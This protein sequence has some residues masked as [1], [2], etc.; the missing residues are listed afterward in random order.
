MPGR[1]CSPGA[2][3]LSARP[4]STRPGSAGQTQ[5]AGAEPSL[6]GPFS[7][8]SRPGHMV[9]GGREG[10]TSASVQR[11]FP[12]AH[13]GLCSRANAA[14]RQLLTKV[15][16]SLHK[17]TRSSLGQSVLSRSCE[18]GS[19]CPHSAASSRCH[20]TGHTWHTAFPDALLSLHNRHLS[21]TSVSMAW[22]LISFY[23]LIIF[24]CMNECSPLFTHSATKDILVASKFGASEQSCCDGP[25]AG[26]VWP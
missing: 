2:C 8:P 3:E 25:R 22:Q 12:R 9:P 15:V 10:R 6:P 4:R 24:H 20:S 18:Q 19:L 17:E 7:N 16:S 13:T 21:F 1:R 11:N 26:C 23:C 5:R 14:R